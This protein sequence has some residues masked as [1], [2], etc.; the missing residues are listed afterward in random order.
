MPSQFARR[1]PLVRV[2]EQRRI[3]GLLVSGLLLAGLLL[4]WVAVW[5]DWLPWLR[6]WGNY[7]QGW[8]WRTFPV[9]PLERFLPLVGVIAAIWATI[10]FAE[11]SYGAPWLANRPAG[12]RTVVAVYLVL[13]VLLGWGLQLGLLGLKAGNPNQ[14][15]VER[16]TNRTFGG[17][18]NHAASASTIDAFFSGYPDVFNTKICPHCHDHPPGPSLYYWLNIQAASSLPRDWQHNLANATWNL[19]GNDETTY[20]GGSL[21][22]PVMRNTLTNAQILGAF[23]GGTFVLVLASMVVLPLFGLARLLKPVP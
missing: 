18:F 21:P 17:Y 10:I 2:D 15:L 13:M 16:V 19:L 12:N 23:T 3:M 22:L 20:F 7:P 11:L 14:L 1:D 6:G 4:Y 5:N 8:T 9:P